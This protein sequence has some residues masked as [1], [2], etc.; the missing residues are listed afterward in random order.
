[1][2]Q[3]QDEIEV[4]ELNAA[5]IKEEAASC[6]LFMS[7]KG[8][9]LRDGNMYGAVIGDLPTG[10]AAF[11]KTRLKA[12]LECVKNLRFEEAKA[13]EVIKHPS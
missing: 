7:L 5:R 2:N 6:E 4:A 10:C 12:I 9:C 8:N 11:E 13:L 1:M 3:Y